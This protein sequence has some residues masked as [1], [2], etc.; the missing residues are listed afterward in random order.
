MLKKNKLIDIV[1]GSHIKSTLG[2]NPSPESV[3]ALENWEINKADAM[4]ILLTAL[5]VG[6]SALVLT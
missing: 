1:D 6:P 3:A 4:L 5:D 2:N